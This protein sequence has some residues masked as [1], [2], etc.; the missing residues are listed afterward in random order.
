[1]RKVRSPGGNAEESRKKQVI[2][3]TWRLI[4][5][6][7]ASDLTIVFYDRLFE[8]DPDIE[9]LFA[10]VDMAHQATKVYEVLQVAVRYLDDTTDIIPL[11]EDIGIRHAR[12][13][14]VV[15]AHYD[16]MEKAFLEAISSTFQS[17]EMDLPPGM[18]A[19]EA[20]D[21]YKWVLGI[22]TRVMTDAA[23]R[24]VRSNMLG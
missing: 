10:K 4:E 6:G 3:Q 13:Y 14:G 7:P 21:A 12:D 18:S 15:K 24:V 2:Q 1:M 23:A 16:I 9:P 11:L 19:A 5:N 8:M 17:E 20:R 22:I